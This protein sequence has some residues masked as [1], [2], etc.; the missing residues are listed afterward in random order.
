MMAMMPGMTNR[1]AGHDAAER[2]VH[3]PA[4][5]GRELL[6]LGP[7]QQ[8][9]VV[10]RVQEPALRNPALL[11]DQDAVHDRDLAGR[12]AEAQARD[13][14]PDPERLAQRHAVR[15]RERSPAATETSATPGLFRGSRP[16]SCAS[17]LAALRHQV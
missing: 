9:A 7:R 3:Q 5:I 16:A 8:H 6:R 15:G 12:T 10:E 2:A 13:A 17:R 14:Q 11:L 4:D 1:H